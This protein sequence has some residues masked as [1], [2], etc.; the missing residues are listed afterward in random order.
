MGQTGRALRL[1]KASWGIVTDDKRLLVLPALSAMLILC[2]GAICFLP[3][4]LF[5]GRSYL[6]ASIP[7]A[8]VLAAYPLTFVSVF[9]RFA[10]VVVV[11]GRLQG[12]AT[13]IRDGLEIAWNRRGSIA[14]WSLVAAAVALLGRALRQLPFLGGLAGSVASGVLGIAWGAVT[15]FVVPVI[16]LEGENGRRAVERSAEIFRRRWGLEVVGIAS[17]TGI[18]VLAV[19]AGTV[20]VLVA[21]AL[22]HT[23]VTAVRVL[24]V[25]AAAWLV[26]CL[27]AG[28]TVHQAFALVLYRYATG[29]S[30]P[31][32][33]DE[34]DLRAAVQPKRR[35][36]FL[37]R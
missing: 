33:F 2:V 21:I 32:G 9:F 24:L 26:A 6:K 18:F 22:V 28:A 11:S 12:R 3:P 36:G 37:G 27:L 31:A 13:S 17:I 23:S 35:R 19:V 7:V 8:G 16:A 1:A 20:V 10:F 5:F 30:L 4:A 34:A 29:R 15:F 25:V 14:H